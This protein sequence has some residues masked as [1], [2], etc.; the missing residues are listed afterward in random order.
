MLSAYDRELL[1]LVLAVEKW[2]GYHMSLKYLWEQP[3]TTI[4]QQKWLVKL[5]AFDFVIVYKQGKE[6]LVA[7]ALSL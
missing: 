5:M 6:N 3:I 2:K 4:Q 7:N 1:T